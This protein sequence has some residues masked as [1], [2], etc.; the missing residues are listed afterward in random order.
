[1]VL[2]LDQLASPQEEPLACCPVAVAPAGLP[3]GLPEAVVV[4]VA[5]LPEVAEVAEVEEP[6]DHLLVQ[7]AALPA[8]LPLHPHKRPASELN[9][10]RSW[11]S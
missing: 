5:G 6:E 8:G 10:S 1:V 2:P 11:L 7:Q 9:T 4:V 3:E